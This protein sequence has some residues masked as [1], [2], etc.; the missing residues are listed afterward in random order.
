M[1]WCLG[2]GND[3]NRI[4]KYGDIF[5]LIAVA[6]AAAAAVGRFFIVLLNTA[7]IGV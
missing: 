6:A 5:S 7:Y 3:V 1:N 4:T 2:E